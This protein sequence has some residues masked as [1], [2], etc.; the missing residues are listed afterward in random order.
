MATKRK[1]AGIYQPPPHHMV[2]DGFRVHG[3]FNVIPDAHEKLSPFLL[4]DYGPEYNFPATTNT[5]RGVGP[6]PHR[7][8][9]TVTIAFAGSVAHHDSAGHGGTIGPGDVQ[10]MTAGGGILHREYHAPEYAKKGGPFQMAQIWVNLPAKHKLAKPGYQGITADQIGV[11][12]LPGGE[13]RV[14][15]G[16]YAGAKG[17]AKTFTPIN[18]YDVRLNK[19][20]R[21]EFSFPAQENAAILIMKGSVS[22]NGKKAVMHDFVLFENEGAEIALEAGEDAQFLVLNGEPI[23]EPVAAYGPFVMNTSREIQQAFDDYRSGKFGH[24]ED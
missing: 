16:E 3:Y 2:G 21:A 23:N 13:V 11:A 12:K 4:L 1:V 10:W 7:G 19:H 8:F 14:I 5:R 6:H 22:V 20:G 18:M 17:P 9:E 15:A 24:L